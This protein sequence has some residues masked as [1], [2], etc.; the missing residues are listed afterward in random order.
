MMNNAEKLAV[1]VYEARRFL[2]R[3]AAIQACGSRSVGTG[4]FYT[5]GPKETGAARRASLDL[6]RSLANL[7]KPS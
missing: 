1:A 5:A 4:A 2:E 6:T 7:R 3:A